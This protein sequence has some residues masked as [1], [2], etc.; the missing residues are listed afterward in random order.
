MVEEEVME[1][2]IL[3]VGEIKVE[4]PEVSSTMFEGH[5]ESRSRS[6][7]SDIKKR[8]RSE[9]SEV[10]KED[11][12]KE[13]AKEINILEEQIRKKQ[14]KSTAKISKSKSF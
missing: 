8:R 2:E 3:E 5:K 7:R 9:D 14:Q 10:K 1:Q 11:R 4:N 12:K 6:Q 13:I